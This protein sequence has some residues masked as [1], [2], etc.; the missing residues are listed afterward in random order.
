MKATSA[1]T[2]SRSEPAQRKK[3]AAKKAPRKTSSEVPVLDVKPEPR[4]HPEFSVLAAIEAKYGKGSARVLGES[5]IESIPSISTGSIKLD[6]ALSIG[7]V[8]RGRIVEVYGVESAGKSTLCLS[9]IAQAQKLGLGAAYI[10]AEHALDPAYASSL[11]V[12]LDRLVLSQPDYGEQALDIASMMLKSGKF[13]VI[14]V[15][16][17]AALTPK[18]EI[19]GEISDSSVGVQ[20]R[21]MGK[22]M[23]VFAS[24]AS[25]AGTTMLF[26]NQLRNKI[27]VRFGSPE[28]TPGGLALKYY[29]SVRLDVR[30]ISTL[31]EGEEAVG[32]QSRVKVVKSKVGRPFQEA[33]IDIRFGAGI[34]R[35]GEALDIGIECGLVKQNGSWFAIDGQRIGQGRKAAVNY[36]ADNPEAFERIV[37][38]DPRVPTV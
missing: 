28:T 31:K 30:R 22:A 14:V 13:A 4:V 27:G 8:P 24:R 21:M 25:H 19:D 36:L 16:S 26:V 1:M 35:F 38:Y 37:N 12:D 2:T 7:G 34:D 11:G 10:D 29:A 18:S 3:K 5:S 32:V 23:R 33:V 20:A 9:V 6:R 17:V 15:D